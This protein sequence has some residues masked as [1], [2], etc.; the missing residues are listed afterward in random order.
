MLQRTIT[1]FLLVAVGGLLAARS[2][3]A[4][5]GA[6]DEAQQETLGVDLPSLARLQVVL[7]D[8]PEPQAKRDRPTYDPSKDIT[9]VEFCHVGGDR[10]L[11]RVTFAAPPRLEDTVLHLYVDADDTHT[12]GRKGS[13]ASGVA[14]TEY[15]LTISRDQGTSSVFSVDGVQSPGPAVWHTVVG[16][17]VLMSADLSLGRDAHG[18]RYGLYVL[19][20]TAT[21][22][23]NPSPPMSDS[24]GKVTVANVPVTDRPKW[25]RPV[26]YVQNHNVSATFGEDLLNATL[27][28][29]G[30]IVVPHDALERDGFEVDLQTT[31]RWPHLKLVGPR[32]A[33]WTT[34]P[35]AGVYHVG[36]MMYDDGNNE[37]LGFFVDGQFLGL[38]AASQNNNRTWLYWLTEPREFRGGERVELRTIGGQGRF[39][40]ANLVFLPQAPE[41]RAI[42]VAVENVAVVTP[43]DRPGLAIVSWTTTWPCP[44][45]LVYGD[46]A[47]LRKH[48]AADAL[49]A[50]SGLQEQ[51]E[52]NRCLVH[53]A[54]LEGLDPAATYC[55]RPIAVGP[56][57]QAVA[58]ADFAFRAAA[59]TA[60]T[61]NE[62]DRVIPLTVRN[63]HDF[64]AV[65]W[66][67][68]T[69]V[70]F[71][72]GELSDV[73]H[74]RLIGETGEVPAQ[75][76][77][78]GR[79]PDGSVKWLLVTFLAD[80]PAAGQAEYRLECGPAVRRAAVAS[81]LAVESADGGVRI[82]TGGVRLR[83]D[84]RGGLSDI[85]AGDPGGSTTQAATDMAGAAGT[86]A[87][88][89]AGIA[90]AAGDGELEIEEAGPIRAVVKSTAPLIAAD[91]QHLAQVEQRIEAYRGLAWVRVRHT[92]V[93]D[94]PQRFTTWKRLTWRLPISGGAWTAR[95]VDGATR[96]LG[97]ANPAVYQLFDDAIAA[98][99]AGG[100]S[101]PGRVVGSLLE[102]G[103]HGWAVAVRDFWQNYP[104]AMR[105]TDDGLQVDLCPA[106]ADGMY[107]AFPF[108]KEGHH[109]YY[110]L[111][112]G[113]YR[114]KQGASKTHELLVSRG[115]GGGPGGDLRAVP[116]TP[117]GHR[118]G[119]GV[120]PESRVL[121]R[122]APQRRTLSG[123]RGGDRS[124]PRAVRTN[125]PATARLRN[126]QL[127][128]LV[129]RTRNELGKRRVRH[130]ARA[131]AGIRPLGQ[132]AG[133]LPGRS[134]R[135]AQSRRGHGPRRGRRGPAGRGAYPLDRPRWRLL[136][137]PRTGRAGL[138]P[139]RVYRVARLDRRSFRPL[140]PD[141]RPP[142]VRDRLCGGR[143][144]REARPGAT[145]RLFR[146]PSPRV[147]PDSGDVR[148]SRDGRSVLFERRSRRRRSRARS[149]GQSASTIARVSSS[150]ANAVST[151]RLVADDG[152]GALSVRTA[153]SGQ[154]GIHGGRAAVRIEI[155]S[156]RD[157][158]GTGQTGDH[159][160]GP[161]SAGRD[162]LGRSSRVPVYV[163]SEDGVS[164]GRLAVDGRRDCSGL[165]VDARRAVPTGVDRGPAAR[166]KRGRLRQ[167]LLAVLPRRPAR[168]GG[169]RS[170][171]P[172]VGPD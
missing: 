135:A 39:G 98:D 112:G 75:I 146:L 73:A 94:G 102:D 163:L 122:G 91:G 139:Q 35:R 18:V 85:V 7:V 64:A 172:R 166:R 108:E 167:R 117:V 5:Q 33:A 99:G 104:K 68:T 63:P 97:A 77:L 55:G 92:L 123:L 14:G 61:A 148:L 19:C 118:P 9:Q 45:R 81:R 71:G 126:A 137:P 110:Y 38:A 13:A 140:L 2:S 12:T 93:V 37:R 111:L 28:A 103:P 17:A 76:R 152:A 6:L 138:C 57:G 82:D 29:P 149:A 20:H 100:E 89:A 58:G 136:R 161:L 168:P 155:L 141:R 115:A 171:W 3:S 142:L 132:S 154:R 49:E 87:E 143:L 165:S 129:W 25:I 106:F 114:L 107:D 43:I 156:R 44:T 24:A 90:Y 105:L 40:I 21:T 162:L 83:I 144:F 42:R 15:M 78:T 10:F 48:H 47:A 170:G 113:R 109:L 50:G 52:T 65:Q 53:R 59:P 69:G 116:T 11:W 131:A 169:S 72:Q 84:G 121:R 119:R 30:V 74:V 31:H 79:W 153:T 60:P 51:T 95:L 56:D 46:E 150:R 158:R 16:N 62:T 147:V 164:A 22:P 86:E 125:P 27:V 34:A 133:V 41:T 70:P 36:F 124:K 120:L 67:I 159:R 54:V 128:R 88:D 130:P 66:P 101:R 127:W 4:E 151:G 80:A 96:R 8:G 134:G 23:E 160:R 1:I 26:D 145:L 32:G 157:R